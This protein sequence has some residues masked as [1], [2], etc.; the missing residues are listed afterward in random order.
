MTT[1]TVEETI[2]DLMDLMPYGLYIVGS[3]KG[4]DVDGMLA[5]W[6]MQLSFRP[7]LVAVALENDSRT[8]ENVRASGVFSVN[9]LSQDADSMALAEKFAQPYYDAKIRGR[10][11]N[12]DPVHHKLER[13]AYTLS[14]FGCPVLEAA[15]AWLDCKVSQLVPVGDHTLVVGEVHD[16]KRVRDGEALTSTYTGW[17]YS[18]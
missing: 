7:R 5:D 3:R 9:L 14:G 13:I 15:M 16:G 12:G 18:G 1:M 4:D 10:G 2:R 17:N 6:V 8:L 11:A